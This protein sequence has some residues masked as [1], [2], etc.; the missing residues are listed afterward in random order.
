MLGYYKYTREEI[1]DI[2]KNSPKTKD[3]YYFVGNFP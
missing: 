1:A 2:I 3:G